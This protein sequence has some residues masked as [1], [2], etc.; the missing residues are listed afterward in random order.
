MPIIKRKLFRQKRDS[1][2]EQY[3]KTPKWERVCNWVIPQNCSRCRLVSRGQIGGKMNFSCIQTEREYICKKV[4]I[5]DTT[6]ADIVTKPLAGVQHSLVSR[7][8][9]TSALKRVQGVN[10]DWVL[11]SK[12]QKVLIDS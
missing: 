4:R 3:G 6:Q 11:P 8:L 2:K 7:L 5:G 12:A 10:E 9:P 1:L